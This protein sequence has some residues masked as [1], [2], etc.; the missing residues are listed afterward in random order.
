MISE[1]L[2]TILEN[3]SLEFVMM[4]FDDNEEVLSLLSQF[5]DMGN[6]DKKFSQI[7]HDKIIHSIKILE[8]II[9]KDFD[10]LD[11]I[12]EQLS[13]VISEIQHEYKNQGP[14]SKKNEEGIEFIDKSFNKKKNTNDIDLRQSKLGLNHPDSLPA[15]LDEETFAQF[16]SHQEDVL[17]RMEQ[18]IL[19]IESSNSVD[20]TKKLKR[21]IHTLK[22]EAGFLNLVEVENVCHQT[23]D[24][25]ES[26]EAV[27]NID[28]Y[29][30]VKDWLQ[31]T[32]AY[33]S[34]SGKE[35]DGLSLLKETGTVNEKVDEAKV[36][37]KNPKIENLESINVN[38][39][40][41]D[42]MV[43]MI[44]EL[45]IAES[46]L[47]Q[48]SEI[49][50]LNSSELTRNFSVMNKITKE[51][52][53]IG[54][55]LRMLPVKSTFQK[56]SRIIR[57]I[58]N[59]SDKD[60]FFLMKGEDTELDRT[61]VEKIG[62][63]L[64]HI[65][66]NA[67]DHG[68]ETPAE[69][70]KKGKNKQATIEMRA[71]QK[72]GVIHIEIEDDGKGIDH[73]KIKQIAIKKNVIDSDTNLSEKELINLIF[74]PGFSTADSVTDLSGRGVG[75]DVV[76]TNI[77]EL[78]GRVGIESSLGKGTTF[79]ISI[80]LT[81]AIIDGMIVR[82]GLE[83]YIIPTLSIITSN[84][85][86]EN[87]INTIMDKGKTINI[88]GDLLPLFSLK[89]LFDGPDDSKE[90]KVELIVV[91]E[92]GGRKAALVVDELLGKQQIVIKNLGESLQYVGGISGGAIMS[93]GV[94]GLILDIDAIIEIA[95]KKS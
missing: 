80:P 20:A 10:D 75:M 51:L 7:I 6:V 72:S 47:S 19:E 26:K 22:G 4:D 65:V 82:V 67:V 35:P 92:E 90:N 9:D 5:K 48:N 13:N 71:Y 8:K 93:D 21:S 84:K 69:R 31:E 63:P 23:E 88:Q 25:L 76:K 58:A 55:S 79:N 70:L 77:E 59:K 45:V 49:K 78:R 68:I 34:G 44:G 56:M 87:M 66:R 38:A 52:Q 95:Q 11:G 29:L 24:I 12:V 46:F 40:R 30:S 64:L 3:I 57:D 61:V 41:L 15:H 37:K 89:E 60:V 16:L 36:S 32:F 94:V 81:L 42:R 50:R 53:E 86:E 43:D 85:L 74:E 18:L 2:N 28:N 83:R 54:L 62:D 33:Y 14:D 91:V 73:E 17:F 39:K 27:K 1:D